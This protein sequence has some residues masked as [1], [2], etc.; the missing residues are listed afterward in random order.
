MSYN[1]KNH[2]N[3][4]M[5]LL[6]KHVKTNLFPWMPFWLHALI[7]TSI[8]WH[9][10]NFGSEKAPKKL[11]FK[12]GQKAKYN[13][14][15]KIVLGRIAET[16]IVTIKNYIISNTNV[17][18]SINGVVSSCDPYWL[19]SLYW[20]EEI[21]FYIYEKRSWEYGIC[22][23]RHSRR[24]IYSGVVQYASWKIEPTNKNDELN[25]ENFGDEHWENF[26]FKK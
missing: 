8:Q 6:K 2:F 1:Y 9:I 13:F 25:W 10:N 3:E 23:G 19:R 26:S 14:R 18:Y 17:E 21:A 11:K 20:W 12:I 24:N 5:R 4:K 7:H 15:G 22:N 16:E